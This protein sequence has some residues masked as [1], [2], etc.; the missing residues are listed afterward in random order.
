MLYRGFKIDITLS[1]AVLLVFMGFIDSYNRD[2]DIC[3]NSVYSF[4]H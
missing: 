4:H 2:K 1:L 3:L